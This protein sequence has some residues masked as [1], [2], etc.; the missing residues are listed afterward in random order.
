MASEEL[1]IPVNRAVME[2]AE[3]VFQQNGLTIQTAINMYLKKVA[4]IDGTQFLLALL[5][6][7]QEYNKAL[8][9]QDDYM[10]AVFKAAVNEAI[11]DSFASGIPVARY[12]VE[13]KKPYMEYPDGRREYR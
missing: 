3:K 13:A 5:K 12:D 9:Q 6:E 4:D 7:E 2:E 8:D 1:N 11:Q 10:T